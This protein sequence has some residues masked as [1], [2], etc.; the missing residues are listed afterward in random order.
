MSI[1][2]LRKSS[3]LRLL[4]RVTLDFEFGVLVGVKGGWAG[5]VEEV[6]VK[7]VVEVE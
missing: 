3:G 2:I 5:V 6:E 1:S 7:W 4:A